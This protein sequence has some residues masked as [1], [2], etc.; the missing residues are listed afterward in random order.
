MKRYIRSASNLHYYNNHL[1]KFFS[2]LSIIDDAEL[3]AHLDKNGNIRDS[4]LYGRGYDNT[5]HPFHINSNPDIHLNYDILGHARATDTLKV[6][7]ELSI[8]YN[9]RTW[10]EGEIQDAQDDVTGVANYIVDVARRCDYILSISD[11]TVKDFGPRI[12]CIT[13]KFILTFSKPADYVDRERSEL[14]DLMDRYGF[15]FLWLIGDVAEHFELKNEE[16]YRSKIKAAGCSDDEIRSICKILRKVSMYG[17][18]NAM[19]MRSKAS[20]SSGSAEEFEYPTAEYE[21]WLAD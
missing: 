3:A 15:C 18:S 9:R 14:D 13:A 7:F 21:A 12:S 19:Y 8:S 6:Q 11:I 16:P 10:S 20:E 2:E 4:T 17:N 1:R 5:S